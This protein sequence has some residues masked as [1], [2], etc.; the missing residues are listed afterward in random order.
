MTSAPSSPEKPERRLPAAF[1]EMVSA[2]PA[3]AGLPEALQTEPEVSV[4]V[5]GAKGA[6]VLSLIHI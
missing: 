5:N 4:R 6:A 3:L 2:Y 1:V